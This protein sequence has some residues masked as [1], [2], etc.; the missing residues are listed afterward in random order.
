VFLLLFTPGGCLISALAQGPVPVELQAPGDSY[1]FGW[2]LAASGNTL[3]VGAPGGSQSPGSAFVF[4]NERGRWVQVAALTASDGANF[5]F[6]G[7]SVGVSGDTVVVGAPEH[8]VGANSQ[9]GAVYVF[10]KP[11][12]GWGDMTETAELTSADGLAG[13]RLGYS[14]AVDG[15]TVV[16]GAANATLGGNIYQGAAYIFLQPSSGWTTM[17]QYKA[18]LTASDGSSAAHFGWSIAINKNTLVVGAYDANCC[19]S[20]YVFVKPTKG[21]SDSTQTAE[22]NA[23]DGASYDFFGWA[24]AISGQTI[25]V[26]ADQFNLPASGKAYVFQESSQGWANMTQTAELT[27][28]DGVPFENF[29]ISVSISGPAIAVGATYDSSTPGAAYVFLQPPGGWI[30]E[31][32][33]KKLSAHNVSSNSFF[34]Q[35]V[36]VGGAIFAGAPFT[37]TGAGAVYFF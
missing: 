1:S 15:G 9:Q 34:G 5:D 33:N 2:S 16:T 12:S 11:A 28:S 37:D 26:G 31:T 19:G 6:F 23:S 30:N 7:L 27:P 3:V 25:C 14:V 20:A 24:V 13:D 32:Q 8:T 29:G 35:S 17:S 22:L 18:K 4:A 36:L 10:V 21:W